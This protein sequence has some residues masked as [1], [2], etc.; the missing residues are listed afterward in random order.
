MITIFKTKNYK[1][2]KRSKNYKTLNT[3][4]ES[5]ATTVIIGA[6]TTSTTLSI[7]VLV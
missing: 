7:K 2:T 1:S 5:V 3:L 6:A 4:L